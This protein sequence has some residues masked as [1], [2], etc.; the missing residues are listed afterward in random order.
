VAKGLSQ[1][2]GK[3]FKENH[4]PVV[5]DTTFHTILVLKILLKLQAGQFES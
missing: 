4:S 1:I 5:N 2:P 3:D